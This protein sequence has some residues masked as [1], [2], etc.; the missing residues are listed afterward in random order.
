MTSFSFFKF[1]NAFELNANVVNYGKTRMYI[2]YE[3]KKSRL[4]LPLA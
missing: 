4:R 1:F 2:K 3:S